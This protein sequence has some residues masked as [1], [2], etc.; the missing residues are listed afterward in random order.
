MTLS[1]QIKKLHNSQRSD[2]FIKQL[3]NAVRDGQIEAA[4]APGRFE[5]PKKF[6]RRSSK[7]TYTRQAKDMIIDATPAFEAWFES[8]N[9]ELAPARNGGK[10]KVSVEAIEAGLVDFSAL[11][12]ATRQ[13]LS[14]SFTKGQALGKSR[15]GS[16]SRRKGTAKGAGKATGGASKGTGRATKAVK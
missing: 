10:I 3:R 5:L 13:K 9:Q 12:A 8:V 16:K 4:D 2:T 6:V 14:A 7:E 1:A 15:S 11:A